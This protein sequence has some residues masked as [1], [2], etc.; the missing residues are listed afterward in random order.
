[1]AF[2]GA[3]DIPYFLVPIFGPIIGASLGPFGYCALIGRHLPFDICTTKET[4]E[5]SFKQ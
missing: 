3:R 2:T 1:M 5:Y 4:D